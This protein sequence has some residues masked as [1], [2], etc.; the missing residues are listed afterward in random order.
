MFDE[1]WRD[2]TAVHAALHERESPGALAEVYAARA[3]LL[4]LRVLQHCLLAF[5]KCRD[6]RRCLC[7]LGEGWRINPDAL[8][9]EELDV[10]V[11]PIV[12]ICPLHRN[13]QLAVH[14]IETVV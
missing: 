9:G 14:L 5:G 3:L 7:R 12:I 1:R 10:L 6:P 11:L 13:G 2:L 4:V 8:A